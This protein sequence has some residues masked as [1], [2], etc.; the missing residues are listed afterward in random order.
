[1]QALCHHPGSGGR[2]A[3]NIIYNFQQLKAA[4]AGFRRAGKTVP[5]LRRH[6]AAAGIAVAD[7]L[8]LCTP[9]R[10]AIFAF[11]TLRFAP[12]IALTFKDFLFA[13]AVQ[14]AVSCMRLRREIDLLG[15]PIFKQ[16]RQFFLFFRV[17]M[18]RVV[19]CASPFSARTGLR[20]GASLRLATL[21]LSAIASFCPRFCAFFAETDVVA[22][23]AGWCI[24]LAYHK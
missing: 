1:M 10:L 8:Q 16:L 19:H 9:Y 18:R 3:R 14:I 15:A 13:L 6:A 21:R 11:F 20:A 12:G 2:Q 5:A 24:R 7:F 4:A 17:R 22:G 23:G